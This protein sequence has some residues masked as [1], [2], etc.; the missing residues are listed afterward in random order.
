MMEEIKDL[1]RIVIEYT[2]RNLPLLDL[3][4][5]EGNGNKELNLFLGLKDGLYSS[6]AEACK[7]IYGTEE[8]DFKFR[9]L[10][11]RLNRKLMNHLYFIDF[12][13]PGLPK[14]AGARQDC[15][16]YLSF[17]RSLLLLGDE[18][19]G[20]KLL[21]KTIDLAKDHFFT[22]IVI[23]C[24]SALRTVYAHQYRPKLFQNITQQLDQFN[25]LKE[26]EEKADKIYYETMLML[27]S[28]INNRKKDL[29]PVEKAIVQ[30]EQKSIALK[31]Y[32]VYEKYIELKISYH[33]LS[34]DYKG[35]LQF[36]DRLEEEFRKGLIHNIRFDIY[37]V[38]QA[39][40]M[41]MLKLKKFEKGMK[42]V[43]D[44]LSE[45]EEENPHWQT[46]M[47]YNFLLCMHNESYEDGLHVLLELFN[48][49]IFETLNEQDSLKWGLYA[50]YA[51]HL[52]GDERLIAKT[53]VQHLLRQTP[54][55]IKDLAGHHV[56][57]LM[58]QIL[59]TLDGDLDLLHEKLTA[60]D[61]YVSKF[62]NNSFG[63]RTKIF[64]K[65]LNK[66]VA[67][68]RDLDTIQVK[69]RYLE[70]KLYAS[71]STPERY[72]DVEV[73]PYEFLWQKA[74]SEIS[75]FKDSYS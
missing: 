32:N 14:S 21:Y 73:V 49:K 47:D 18:N 34:G 43:D 22:D 44:Y 51:Y 66:L 46:L 40:V 68:N 26:E 35:L 74:L 3:K 67:H 60:L 17:S 37:L 2:K 61:D 63:K 54:A 59:N 75:A 6:D 72:A 28:T 70:E 53:S 57:V 30:L 20:I 5:Q 69:S 16:D 4:A 65:L 56:A 29:K 15:Q 42:V 7:G 12:N 41:A 36:L 71:G 1:I 23:A 25:A 50:A 27:N 48:S 55:Y 38:K 39:R 52:T 64:A 13:T 10:K 62:L 45:L 24:L 31:S 11:S 8:V 58:V 33:R 9:M 19:L